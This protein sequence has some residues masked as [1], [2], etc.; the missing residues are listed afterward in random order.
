[1]AKDVIEALVD[2]GKA[3]AGPPLGPALGPMGIN[4][5]QVISEINKK[6]AAFKGMQVP[7]KVLID[8]AAK[9]FDITVGTPPASAL[10]KKE[11]G[12]EKGSRNPLREKVAD[13]R[14]EQVIKVAQM[15]EDALSG[16]DPVSRVREIIGTCQ[17]MGVMVQGKPAFE[18]LQDIQKG[19][20]HDKIIAGKT[21]LTAEELKALEEE[22]VRLQKEIELRRA[23]WENMAKSIIASM[24]GKPRGEIKAKLVE[25]EIPTE[26]ITA[27]LPAEGLTSAAEAKEAA[28]K[29]GGKPAAGAEAKKPEAKK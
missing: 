9:T 25:A 10:L 12:I 16:R 20:Y 18:T 7:V 28:K 3:T 1:M 15:K 26:L 27:L 29:E 23:E 17:S 5:G 24:A 14:I 22:R 13:L 19:M 4:I 11:A 6:T 21:E 8:K 2:G